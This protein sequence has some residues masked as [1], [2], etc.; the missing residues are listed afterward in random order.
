M[1]RW[2]RMRRGRVWLVPLLV[3]LA[4]AAG[5]AP[6][7][8]AEEPVAPWLSLHAS[9][10]PAKLVAGQPGTVEIVAAN[11]GTAEI[12]PAAGHPIKIVDTLPAGWKVTQSVVIRYPKTNGSKIEPCTFS[13]AAHTVTC[14][15]SETLAPYE[16]FQVTIKL[17]VPAVS[18]GE[19]PETIAVEGAEGPG[20]PLETKPLEHKLKVGTEQTPFGIEQYDFTPESETGGTE[21]QAGAH[22]FQLTTFLH[23]N[24]I[25]FIY[26][27]SKET[28]R[29]GSSNVE[30]VKNVRVNLPA[31]LVG[32]TRAVPQ[33]SAVD[34]TTIASNGLTA[35]CPKDTVIGAADVF[36]DEVFFAGP[37]GLAEPVYNLEPEEGEPA[38]FGFV[39]EGGVP[40]TF[41]TAVNGGDF[42]VVVK[43]TEAPTAYPILSTLV[44]IWGSP[45]D[46]RHD[47]SR[48]RDCIARGA[49]LG[50]TSKEEE[51]AGCVPT[52]ES[53]RAKE[54]FL[55]MPT[56]CG[57]P[58]GSDASAQPWT[59][60]KGFTTPVASE[61]TLF[62]GCQSVPFSPELSIQ[63]IEHQASTPTGLKVLLK[64]PQKTT[65]EP[66]K[67]IAEADIRNTKVVFPEGMQLSPSASNG[68]AACSEQEVGFTGLNPNTG[69]AEFTPETPKVE[70]AE[71]EKESEAAGRLCPAASKVGKVRIK[72]P[73]LKD[74]LVGSV[75]LAEQEHNPYGSL[76]GV[77]VVVRDPKTGVAIKLAGKVTLN[78]SNGQI[79]SE[80]NDAPQA[81]F[82]EFELELFNGPRASLA[83]PA[84]C[85]TYATAA[86][87]EP[88]SGTP[89]PALP[90]EALA[91]TVSQGPE[92]GACP[93]GTLPLA[94]GFQAGSSSQ[95]AGA[96]APFTVMLTRA[97]GQQQPTNLTM[98]FPPGISG[99]LANVKQCPEP[100]ANLGTCGP[101]SLIGHASATVGLGSTPFTVGGGRV[102]ITGP[103]QG[104]PFGLSVVL[105][106]QAGPFNFGYVVT[107]SK[108]E[109]NKTTAQLTVNSSL[110]TF[111]N[112]LGYPGS[113]C[114]SP[115]KTGVPVQLRQV[116]VT[117]ERP[118]NAP[119]QFNP[120]N[121][122]PM[123]I[124][125]TVT[126]D[127]GAVTPI[128]QPFQVH[129]CQ[130][131]PFNPE[132]S[133]ET[134]G[135]FTRTEGTFL[136]VTVKEK[137]GEANIAKTKLV[138]P[139]QLPSRLTTLQQACLA[140][141][142][143]QNPALCPHASAIGTA[144]AHTPVLTSPLV[145][146]VYLVS[147]GGA[148]FP[149]AEFILQ[150]E[151]VTLLLDGKTNIHNGITSS[152][153]ESVP[154]A[155]V[156]SFEVNL[157][158]GPFS[159]FTGY[160]NLCEPT[161]TENKVVYKTV[162]TGKG[163][164]KRKKK[165]RKTVAVKVPV[166]LT[167]P[168]I[169]TGQNGN[170]ITE[171]LKVHVAECQVVKSF[172]QTKP[173]PKHKKH[174]HKKASSKH[175]HK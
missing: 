56:F 6:A 130:N 9:V 154:D 98:T 110:P 11:L 123:S 126:G 101:E 112:T 161:K 67:A 7:L 142:F 40:V 93:T 151:G 33:C 62:T 141:T 128:S 105:P 24:T 131:L 77:Y 3:A 122:S 10:I 37:V 134:G 36:I 54:S 94:P 42:H 45:G 69:T 17:G 46:K 109:V 152:T 51:E 2:A 34:F 149:D 119:F 32:D 146:P 4:A 100:Q 96:F 145:G 71:Q 97:P 12:K 81:P 137:P 53:E 95:Q 164:H 31:G 150:G 83:T 66:G 132:F 25:P 115:C 158:K 65:L 47:A 156:S 13:E 60:G 104:A 82:E 79:T 38:R 29:E 16:W 116:I 139:L 75:Y 50:G 133:V 147:H 58:L 43:V 169:L 108:I 78:E 107:R 136:K 138:F 44:T 76:F 23:F 166:P 48:G 111:V 167:A 143:E 91:F 103:Y 68:L 124:T 155:P 144:T 114:S 64:S 106:A 19:Y 87:I 22:P 159:A 121:C 120:T 173:K 73:L 148:A 171:E 174:K 61:P 172:K 135:K 15:E 165:V 20:G 102:Y 153:F 57:A 18:P 74:E 52:A 72:T 28:T 157:P 118:G 117:V 8:A 168:T 162:T 14:E 35:K 99:M 30:Q 5:A 49:L 63:P 41:D 113:A 88:W 86:T 140:A 80:F 84:K 39:A 1:T 160:E 90:T 85:G 127:E 70:T 163:K 92:G 21:T 125:G 175:R 26:K 55:D 170:V 59:V 89:P 27:P 129:G